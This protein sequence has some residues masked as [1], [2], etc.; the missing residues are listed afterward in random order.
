[1]LLVQR[2]PGVFQG[3]RKRHGIPG[4]LSHLLSEEGKGHVGKIYVEKY[5][6]LQKKKCSPHVDS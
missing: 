5:T 3:P 4:A 1:M 6:I 2:D